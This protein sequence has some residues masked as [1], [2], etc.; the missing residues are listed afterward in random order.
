MNDAIA[1]IYALQQRELN[2]KRR[3]QE[4]AQAKHRREL[5]A[6]Q[7]SGFPT[8]FRLLASVPLRPEVQQRIHCPDFQSLGWSHQNP[9]NNPN[10]KDVSLRDLHGNSGP[11]WWCHESLDS[12]RMQYCYRSG[13]TGSRDECFETPDGDWLNAFIE[14]AAR[15]CDPDII[16]QIL[17]TSA[18]EPTPAPVRR[19]IQPV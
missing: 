4:M 1:R 9:A 13:S 12:G 8:V 2:E 5:A 17:S 19:Q 14:Y 6:F 11:R 3:Q 7:N 16:A 10:M 15:A 18:Q